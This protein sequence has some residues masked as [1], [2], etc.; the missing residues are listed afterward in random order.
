[1]IA[2]KRLTAVLCA[3]VLLCP[4]LYA[5]ASGPPA[6]SAASAIL[7]DG[8]SGR[9]LFEQNARQPRAIASITKLMT[10]LVAVEWGESLNTIVT[11]QPE[12]TGAE[13]SSIYLK[14]GEQ[15]TLE[16][17][18]YGLMLASGNDAAVAVACFCAGD[19]AS[20]VARMNE[21]AQQLGMEDTHFANPNGLD[22]EEH[23]STAYDMVLLARACLENET[24][25]AIVS[26]RSATFGTRTFTNHNKL[27]WQYEG[28]AGLKTGYT[29]Q[30]GR[31]LVSAARRDGQTLIAVTL[32]DPNDWADHAALFDYGFE[33]FPRQVLCTAGEGFGRVPVKGSLVPFVA[34]A[35]AEELAWPMTASEQARV[36]VQLPD[37]VAAP[38]EEGDTVGSLT[39][40]VGQAPVGTTELTA[41]SA[42][43]REVYEDRSLLERVLDYLRGGSC[44]AWA[45]AAY[46]QFFVTTT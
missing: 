38:V 40:Y 11:I 21:K 12:W 17:L 15:L 43:H 28:C 23:Y 32:S 2:L 24:V 3:A 9:V 19:V 45:P 7:V 35:A 29:Q 16:T 5:S 37:T 41:C 46:Q 10:C 4:A 27:L 22:D 42:V 36:Q 26:A 6:L 20:F 8:E 25:A 1:M 44:P 14:A 30:A 33:M 31:T 18:L 13:G 39:F 34:V